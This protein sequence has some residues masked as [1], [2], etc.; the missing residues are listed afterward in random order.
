M[1]ILSFG[2]LYIV[3]YLRTLIPLFAQ[4]IIDVIVSDSGTASTLPPLLLSFLQQDTLA[5][6]L[7]AA[8]GLLLLVDFAARRHNFRAAH[9]HRVFHR[10]GCLRTAQPLVPPVSRFESFIY[11]AHAQTG[12]LIQR[13]TTDISKHTSTSSATKSSKSSA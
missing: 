13:A 11:H 1:L 9:R 8:A 10:A 5:S 2:L 4:H 7:L 3:T 12:D 6:Q